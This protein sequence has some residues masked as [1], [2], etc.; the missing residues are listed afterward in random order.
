M[1]MVKKPIIMTV[2]LFIST[3]VV[4]ELYQ[5]IVGTPAWDKALSHI[6]EVRLGMSTD[7][8]ASI[9]GSPTS[10]RI[11]ANLHRDVFHYEPKILFRSYSRAIPWVRHPDIAVG[12]EYGKVKDIN[13]FPDADIAFS[14]DDWKRS[15]AE[16]RGCMTRDLLRRNL[17]AGKTKQE[18]IDLLGPAEKKSDFADDGY[19][20]YHIGRFLKWGFDPN[21]LLIRFDANGKV[22]SIAVP[23]GT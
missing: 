23:P 16:R 5:L 15:F 19:L 12:F 9:L 20:N 22:A 2:I 6:D 14:P 3:L 13:Y 17:L 4:V 21:Y 11:A 1:N 7:Q 10:H 8:V 18:V